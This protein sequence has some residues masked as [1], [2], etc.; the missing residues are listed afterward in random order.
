MESGLEDRN[1]YESNFPGAIDKFCLNGVRPRR[2]EQFY[3]EG[4]VMAVRTR[5]SM[6]SGLEDRNN[7]PF[8]APGCPPTEMSQ[9]SPA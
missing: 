3:I 4:P 5:V 6:E 7:L 9:W 2:P 8:P 1:N